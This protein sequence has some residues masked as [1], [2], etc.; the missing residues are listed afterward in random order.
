MKKF[1]KLALAA[2][3]AI[4]AIAGVGCSKS[5]EK[6]AATPAATEKKEDAEKTQR[7][8]FAAALIADEKLNNQFSKKLDGTKDGKDTSYQGL[9]K[10]KED[11]VKALENYWNA[12]AAKKEIDA[13][14]ADAAKLEAINAE[15]KAKHE[16]NEAAKKKTAEEKKEEFKPTEFKPA[17]D[18]ADP[19]KF[20][21]NDLV[22][23][24]ADFKDAKVTENGGKFTVEYK[25]L[26]YTLE[27]SGT[28]YK[29][30]SKEG[31]L[32]K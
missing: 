19:D 12:D 11:A 17:T 31:K 15:L 28:T 13:I 18:V 30:V 20:K 25:G 3:L 22:G 5:E 6:P 1:T 2:T 29:V 4:T 23:A 9:A 8:V 24:A 32:A 7:A 27:K 16:A 26:K 21:K 10:S 14:V